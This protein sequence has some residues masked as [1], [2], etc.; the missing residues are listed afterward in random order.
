METKCGSLSF[1]ISQIVE[2][3]DEYKQHHNFLDADDREIALFSPTEP[4]DGEGGLSPSVCLGY[5]PSSCKLL[6]FTP[7]ASGHLISHTE[8]IPVGRLFRS[9]A[10][11]EG[12]FVPCCQ[13]VSLVAVTNQWSALRCI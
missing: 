11:L 13:T 9:A 1:R 7:H 10:V 2:Q 6:V 8:A 5:T 12:R 4:K 3:I